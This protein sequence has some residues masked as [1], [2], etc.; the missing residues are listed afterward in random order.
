MK[1]A[2][3]SK[4]A[5]GL[6]MFGLLIFLS[7]GLKSARMMPDYAMVIENYQ[8]DFFVSPPC[9]RSGSMSGEMPREK[10][11]VASLMGEDALYSLH[12]TALASGKRPD[13]VCANAD[14]FVENNVLL[15]SLFG[16]P[17]FPKGR[18]WN[19]DGSWNY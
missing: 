15:F 4:L 16:I 8:T 12:R 18:R 17:P 11:D 6:V 10:V 19:R 13:P 1:Q 7:L 14:G 2:R 3:S 5:V 9:F